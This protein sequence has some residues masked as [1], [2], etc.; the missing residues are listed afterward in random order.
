MGQG[1]LGA[2][3]AK[4]VLQH[5]DKAESDERGFRFAM[6]EISRLARCSMLVGDA[7]GSGFTRLARSIGNGTFINGRTCTRVNGTRANT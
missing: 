1:L 4:G 6:L 5:I 2:G 3:V 7:G